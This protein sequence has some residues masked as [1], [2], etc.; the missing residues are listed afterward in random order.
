M[1]RARTTGGA[2]LVIAASAWWW[3]GSPSAGPGDPPPPVLEPAPEVPD[4]EAQGAA[5]VAR[6]QKLAR[7]KKLGEAVAI[8]EQVATRLPSASHDC[9]LA[10]AYL[11]AGALT[12]A[13]LRWDLARLR[14]ARPPEWCTTVLAAEL[15]A[16]LRDR[17]FVPLAITVSPADATIEIEEAGVRLRRLDLVWVAPGMYTIGARAEGMIDGEAHVAV[18]PP[19][20]RVQITLAAPVVEPVPAPIDAAPPVDAA[21]APPPEVDAAPAIEVLPVAP[22]PRVSWPGYAGAAIGGVALVGGVVMH[23]GAAGTREDADQLVRGTPEF[24]RALD[25]FERQRGLAIAGYVVA[26]AGLGFAGWWV[27]GRA[28]EDAARPAVGLSVGG[29]GAAVTFEWS[30]P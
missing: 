21:V 26:A 15:A 29:D 18:A 13:Q 12:K 23:V 16:A 7:T 27:W 3:A 9:N 5:E 8:L 20:A 24:G 25:R 10:L 1:R 22:P 28:G 4:A 11:R 30:T 2:A 6:A 14:K 17:G 19:S